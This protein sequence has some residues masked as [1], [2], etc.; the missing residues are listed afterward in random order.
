MKFKFKYF[1]FIILFLQ[2]SISS[3]SQAI[4]PIS[5]TNWSGAAPVGWSDNQGTT[6]TYAS[7]VCGS[8]GSIS[9]RLDNAGENFVVNYN[10]GAS[11]LSFCLK[12]NGYTP[13]QFNVEESVAGVVWTNVQTITAISATSSSFTVVLNCASRYVRFIYTTKNVGNI[14]IDDVI[15]TQGTC[16]GGNTITTGAI[17]T[18]PFNLA[19]CTSTAS[20]SVAF[21]SSGIFNAG[22]VYTAQLSDASGSFAAPVNIGTLSSTA[23]SGSIPFTLPAGT[24]AGTGYIIRI[25]SSNPSIIGSN[26]TAFT[27]TSGCTP[28][29]PSLKAALIN[30]CAG[31]CSAEGN[32]E[33]IILNSGSYSIPVNPTN[34][35][36]SFTGTN[37]TTGFSAQ[38]SVVSN[39][40]TLAGCGSLFID[41]SASGVIPPNSNFMIMN[42]GSCFDFNFSGYCSLAPIYVA[43]SNAASWPASGFF[44]NGGASVKNFVTNFT[45]IS[46]TC[47]S[48]TYTYIP[49]DL[50]TFASSGDGASVSWATIGGPATYINEGC[51]PPPIVLPI[52]LLDFY[53]SKN[54]SVNELTWK[55]AQEENIQSYIIEKSNDGISF[56]EFSSVLFSGNNNAFQSKVYSLIDDS[57]FKEVTYYRLNT[58]ENNGKIYKH[59]IISIDQNEKGW[60][61]FQYIENNQ[62]HVDFKNLVPKNSMIKLY[63]I[64]GKELIKVDVTESHTIIN[65]SELGAGIYFISISS[66]YKTENFKII[67]SK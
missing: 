59:K 24:L 7:D 6:P 25:I 41:V 14:A 23:N 52:Q 29:C 9:G 48:S 37:F 2:I 45:S 13:G 3:I 20:G 53:G 40:N 17:T 28:V 56:N 1:L 4:I 32:N 5:R 66:P 10:T 26:S 60:Q 30:G 51:T 34:L 54:G 33:L 44:T 16:G 22:N 27:I 47:G 58:K 39:L 43:F 61:Y 42:T 38:P 11:N 19:T 31:P 18:A 21:S 15:I 12:G 62:L 8:S 67:L 57:P 36:I 65:T 63:D 49:N 55:V 50:T 46:A 35:N 64:T